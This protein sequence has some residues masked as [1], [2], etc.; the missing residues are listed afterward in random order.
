MT[1]LSALVTVQGPYK[2]MDLLIPA[3]VAIQDLLPQLLAA[4]GRDGSDAP[5][6]AA[7]LW[8]LGRSDATMPFRATATLSLEG[9]QDGELLI[10]QDMAT[11]Q[12]WQ[13]HRPDIQQVMAEMHITWN[14]RELWHV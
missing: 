11:W 12:R 7:A 3:E 14:D 8:G 9:V 4:L 10:L 5:G 6:D 2:T 13:Q 1:E